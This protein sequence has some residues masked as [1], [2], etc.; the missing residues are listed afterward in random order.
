M[1]SAERPEIFLL[2]LEFK[3]FLDDT[4]SSLF[5]SL[6]NSAAVK[7]AKTSNGA[8]RYLN[9]NNPKAI[10]VTDEGLTETGNEAVFEKLK[11]YV[12]NGGLVIVGL[13]FPNFTTMDVFDEFF[14]E[15]FGLPW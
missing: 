4:Y 1:A 2:S 5:D 12:R 14:N 9:A 6:N 7:R 15:G 11:A 10:L 8:I 3:S 13:H